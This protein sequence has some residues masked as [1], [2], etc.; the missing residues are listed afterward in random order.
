MNE[1]ELIQLL[2]ERNE[3]AFKQLVEQYKNKIYSTIL[4]ILQDRAEAEDSTQDV[5]IQV[6]ESIGSFK[7]ESSLSTWIY[8]IAVRKAFDKLRRQKTRKTL[9]QLL[10]WWMP[11]EKGKDERTFFHPEVT[12]ENKEKSQALF[13]AMNS[14][15]ERQRIAVTLIKIEGMS[16]D[17]ASKI[18][19]LGIK[20]IESLVSRGKENLEKKLQYQKKEY[21]NK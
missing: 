19:N 21:A 8:T 18:M 3:F 15:P 4:N 12:M 16:Y 2:C 1:T 14:L 9:H 5:F 10:P 17:E 6:F 7:K 13:N 11:Q 20:A